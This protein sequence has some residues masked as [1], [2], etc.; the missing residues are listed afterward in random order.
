MTMNIDNQPEE[1][2]QA[3]FD[4]WR[5]VR[6][7]DMQFKRYPVRQGAKWTTEERRVTQWWRKRVTCSFYF[8][9]RLPS[10]QSEAGLFSMFGSR[11]SSSNVWL[12]A[13][14]VFCLN[15]IQPPF[16][17]EKSI[18]SHATLAEQVQSLYDEIQLNAVLLISYR[19][20]LMPRHLPAANYIT[21]RNLVLDETVFLIQTLKAKRMRLVRLKIN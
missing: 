2:Y 1:G 11:L 9:L 14:E 4:A 7:L 8:A 18:H 21:I 15:Y 6:H 5:W 17:R 12:I 16:W 20:E 19:Y 13:L 3:K 10:K